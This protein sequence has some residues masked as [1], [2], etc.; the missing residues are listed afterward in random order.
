MYN[1][2]LFLAKIIVLNLHMFLHIQ[3]LALHR[4]LYL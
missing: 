4:V 3:A 2:L 1:L